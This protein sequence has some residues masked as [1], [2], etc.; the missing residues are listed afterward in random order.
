M[1]RRAGDGRGVAL[2]TSCS[3]VTQCGC[4]THS[5]THALRSPLRAPRRATARIRTAVFVFELV[6]MHLKSQGTFMS[7]MLAFKNC[8]FKLV[9][10]LMARQMER[11]YDE[12]AAF[13]DVS[14]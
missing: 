3:R 10:R 12:S 2:L 13:W 5:H 1:V 11:V 8:E 4:S 6:A 9:D 7:R 14:N